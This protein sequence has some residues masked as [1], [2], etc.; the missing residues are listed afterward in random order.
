M[1]RCEEATLTMLLDNRQLTE[2]EG[3][4]PAYP[5]QLVARQRRLARP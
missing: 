4:V 5:P 1:G 3:L 2:G